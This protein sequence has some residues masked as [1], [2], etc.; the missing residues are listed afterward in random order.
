MYIY[1]FYLI[2]F[3]IIIIYFIEHFKLNRYSKGIIAIIM[4]FFLIPLITYGIV[5]KKY[6]ADVV[7][8]L[9][10]SFFENVFIHSSNFF[11]VQFVAYINFY[12]NLAHIW[13]YW[14]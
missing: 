9:I 6:S 3:F 7:Q 11:Y 8:M 1:N 14:E 4:L 2:F 13:L 5:I 10:K 12:T